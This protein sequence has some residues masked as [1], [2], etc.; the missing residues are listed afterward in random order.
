QLLISS[1]GGLT[2]RSILFPLIALP[3]SEDFAKKEFPFIVTLTTVFIGITLVSTAVILCPSGLYIVFATLVPLAVTVLG[4][5]PS[6][7][8]YDVSLKVPNVR[9]ELTELALVLTESFFCSELEALLLDKTVLL[10]LLTL[11]NL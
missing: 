7:T 10:S 8:A 5:I 2:S 3:V 6:P 9:F 4:V 1:H 11:A